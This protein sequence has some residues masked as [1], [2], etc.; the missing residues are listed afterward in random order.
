MTDFFAQT[1]PMML[2]APIE[3]LRASLNDNEWLT[4]PSPWLVS[5]QVG[6]RHP[7]INQ[8]FVDRIQ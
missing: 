1:V 8:G 2:I 6:P 3:F 7:L 4:E 5:I